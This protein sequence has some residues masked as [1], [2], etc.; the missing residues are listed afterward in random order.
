MRIVAIIILIGIAM[1][2]FSPFFLTVGNLINLIESVAILSILAFGITYVLLV[3]EMDMSVGSTM[4]ISAI[5]TNMIL[6]LY[7]PTP[8]AVAG[9]IGM[10]VVIG[11]TNGVLIEFLG[12]PSLIV[13]LAMMSIL[14]GLVYLKTGNAPFAP[15]LDNSASFY[16]FSNGKLFGVIPVSVV[17]TLVILLLFSIIFYKTR[18]GRAI[19]MAGANRKAANIAGKNTKVIYFVMFVLS[20]FLAGIAGNFLGSKLF[21]V[22]PEFGMGYELRAITASVIGGVSLYGGRGSFLSAFLGTILIGLIF[23]IIELLG[24]GPYWQY[25]FIGIV[26]LVAILADKVL[27]NVSIRRGA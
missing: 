21:S 5:T 1:T 18:F 23:N 15:P 24:F 25:L 17:V 3:G 27:L 16:F 6:G 26:V 12:F 4:A 10:G 8:I 9:G 7:M 2:I 14:R 22:F 13:T 19:I 11:A 20:G